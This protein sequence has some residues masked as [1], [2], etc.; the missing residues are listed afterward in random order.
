M[1][2][3]APFAYVQQLVCVVA[4]LLLFVRRVSQSEHGWRRVLAWRRLRALQLRSVVALTLVCALLCLLAYS[5]VLTVV[6]YD[7]VDEDRKHSLRRTGAYLWTAHA[8]LRTSSLFLVVAEWYAMTSDIQ[9]PRS[10]SRFEFHL[11]YVWTL[12]SACLHIALRAIYHAEDDRA[13]TNGHL[14]ALVPQLLYSTELIVVAAA[15]LGSAA[16]MRRTAHAL[17]T[18]SVARHVISDI[19]QQNVSLAGAVF[20]DATALLAIK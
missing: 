6:K 11:V 4:L 17:P 3:L 18:S 12:V 16:R 1:S 14:L 7:R 19:A 8:V 15:F 2:H 13:C 20:A 10:L 5:V 9:T